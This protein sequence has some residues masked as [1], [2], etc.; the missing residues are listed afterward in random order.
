MCGEGEAYE[1]KIDASNR[2]GSC[3]E[4]VGLCLLGREEYLLFM[5][6]DPGRTAT[7]SHTSPG[8]LGVGESA[9]RAGFTDGWKTLF[10]CDREAPFSPHDP[11]GHA[12]SWK[13]SSRSGNLGNSRGNSNQEIKSSP[14]G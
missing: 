6:R 4:H 1:L 11:Q 5:P 10:L 3:R 8:P 2:Q 7:A 14:S 13:D 9:D 12:H